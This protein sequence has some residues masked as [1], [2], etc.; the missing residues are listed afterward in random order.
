[1]LE[2]R[3]RLSKELGREVGVHP[4]TEHP[5]YHASI[6]KAV[7]PAL[8]DALTKAGLNREGAP[9]FVQSVETTNLQ[10][11]HGEL[12]VPLVPLLSAVGAPAD[13]A[14]AGDPRTCADLIT[15]EELADIA[16][17]AA[18]I[19]PDRAMV[20]G[21]DAAGAL[22]EPTSLVA[23]AHAVG[24]LVHPYTFRDENQSLPTS[25]REGASPADD[26][27]AFAEYAAFFAAGVDGVFADH[28]DTA[29]AACAAR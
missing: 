21:R 24:L 8:V 2:L 1:V 7:G 25:L 19:G 23:D 29:V 26:G 14:A 18:G 28:P 9:V 15:P 16:T 10:E 6:G 20:I 11:L 12:H 13:L 5:T 17:Y 4:E 22:A 27:D 3:E